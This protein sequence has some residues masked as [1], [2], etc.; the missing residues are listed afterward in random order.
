MTERRKRRKNSKLKK[1]AYRFIRPESSMGEVMYALLRQL[2]GAHHEDLA[3]AKIALAWHTA[4]KPDCDGHV[5]LGKC[6]KVSDLERE[7]NE[8]QP[9][10][11]VII[12]RKDFWD[13]PCVTDLQRRALLDH[14][15]CH[16]SITL[17]DQGEPLQDERGRTVYR[18]RR[19]DLEEFAAIA[20]RYGCWKKDLE[21]FARSLHRAHQKADSCWVAYGSLQDQL[22]RVGVE[23]L[24][25]AIVGWTEPQ[26]REAITW[27]MLTQELRHLAESGHL[28]RP[29]RTP[30]M[31]AFL[32]D[33]EQAPE[34]TQDTL[35]PIPPA[36]FSQVAS[37]SRGAD[38][39]NRGGI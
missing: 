2:V 8:L 10:D 3:Q 31:P 23:V 36:D 33:P 13:D 14:E 17:D 21:Q 22:R 32:R 9:Y 16:A 38:D 35:P 1:V 27:A 37:E 30:T 18:I 26:R 7:V 4:W 12:L 28:S 11:F 29:V 20:E 6:R 19:H 39:Q 24:L 34:P 25:D 15:L 5:T